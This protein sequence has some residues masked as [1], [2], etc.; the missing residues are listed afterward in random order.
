[1]PLCCI[2]GFTT[3]AG[4]QVGKAPAFTDVAGEAG[5]HFTHTFGAKKL[6]N[7][8]MTTGSGCALFDYDNDG[9][10]D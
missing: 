2:I 7:V 9:W 5:L 8:L 4:A 10:L 6:E 1:M 3:A